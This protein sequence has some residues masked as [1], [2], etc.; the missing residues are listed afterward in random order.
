MKDNLEN[1]LQEAL[2]ELRE[3]SFNNDMISN[4]GIIFAI[5]K[6]YF[7]LSKD[8]IL[9]E[10]KND[11]QRPDKQQKM[12]EALKNL[13]LDEI[14]W[15]INNFINEI[16]AQLETPLMDFQ[17]D[18][19]KEIIAIIL[20]IDSIGLTE[21]GRRI[22]NIPIQHL[23]NFYKEPTYAHNTDSGMDIYS[24]QEFTI[25]PGETKIIPTGIKIAIP[26][27][28]EMQVRPRSGL[29]AKTKLRIANAPGT[30]KVFK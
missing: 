12:F 21:E 22:I 30:I 13:N 7:L 19:L 10:I 8:A 26:N 4:L 27:G 6:E 28:Y 20:N 2:K 17:K 14:N 1:K 9:Q 3:K 18:F 11:F 25:H 15:I 24:P 29:S 23:D 5:P 16:Q